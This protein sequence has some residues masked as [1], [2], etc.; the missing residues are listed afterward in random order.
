MVV[1]A[2][3]ETTT[4]HQSVRADPREAGAP[5]AGVTLRT[6]P[7]GDHL[8]SD[9]PPTASTPWHWPRTPQGWEWWYLWVTKKAINADYLVHDDKPGTSRDQRTHLVHAS[10]SRMKVPIRV[11]ANT[12]L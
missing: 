2:R 6:R 5:Q 3:A 1:S 9:I 7:G 12:A 10:C 8:F 11:A 4:S